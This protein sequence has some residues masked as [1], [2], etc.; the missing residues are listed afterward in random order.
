MDRRIAFISRWAEANGFAFD[1][2][3]PDDEILSV[4]LILLNALYRSVWNVVRGEWN[5]IPIEAFD[6]TVGT[7]REGYAGSTCA[8]TALPI[9]SPSLLITHRSVRDSVAD[10]IVP[11]IQTESSAFDDEWEVRC[12]DR[13]FANAVVHQRLME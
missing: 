13:F 4:P 2:A 7:A 3:D 5:D 1:I 9:D 6:L 8:I 11:R 12:A 10:V